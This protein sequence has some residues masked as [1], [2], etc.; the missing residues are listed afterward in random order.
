MCASIS[1]QFKNPYQNIDKLTRHLNLPS[2]YYNIDALN[3]LSNSAKAIASS[4]YFPTKYLNEIT[5]ASKAMQNVYLPTNV[6]NAITASINSLSI[7]IKAFE[8]EQ[9]TKS[10]AY[11]NALMAMRAFSTQNNY[12]NRQK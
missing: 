8:M 5:A 10:Q 6:S 9:F 4:F 2:T 3:S 12:I 7:P 11:E 1:D